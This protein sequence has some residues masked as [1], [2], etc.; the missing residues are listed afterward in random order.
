M[1]E[2]LPSNF[3]LDET[4]YEGGGNFICVSTM[5]AKILLV[6]SDRLPDAYDEST[7]SVAAYALVTSLDKHTRIYCS[8]YLFNV[9]ISRKP[10]TLPVLN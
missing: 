2:N 7:V 5:T 8:E 4:A 10:F 6:V 9:A 3:R 1:E